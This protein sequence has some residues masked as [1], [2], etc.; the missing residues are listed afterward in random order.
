MQVNKR[1]LY[2]IFIVVI[3]GC[4]IIYSFIS[5]N[6]Q[7][8]EELIVPAEEISQDEPED[9]NQIEKEI[10][11]Q[12]CGAIVNEGVYKVQFG[13]RIFEAVNMA[14]GLTEDASIEAVN[15]ARLAKDGEQIYFPTKDEV[16]N[17]SF[18][19]PGAT[20]LVNINSASKEQLMTLPGI[21]ES[22]ALSI[23]QF[24]ES[25]D[26]F[27]SIEDIKKVNGIKDAMFNKIKD[28]ITI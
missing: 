12:L 7:E 9:Q 4:G 14:G 3:V 17:G 26:G 28:L 27:T 23:I 10:Y 11:I 18:I 20:S 2:T 5:S 15:Q 24:R 8:T 21:G 22:K 6:L 1:I 25:N 16:N 13:T 19:I